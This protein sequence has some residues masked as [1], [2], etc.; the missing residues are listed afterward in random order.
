MYTKRKKHLLAAII[1]PAATVGILAIGPLYF[2]SASAQGCTALPPLP[3]ITHLAATA[4]A[5]RVYAGGGG[6]PTPPHGS[7]RRISTIGAGKDVTLATSSGRVIE[8]YYTRAE[9][10]F[11][12]AVRPGLYVVTAY[13]NAGETIPLCKPKT[14][15]VRKHERKIVKLSCSSVP[16]V[17]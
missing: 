2:R 7:C 6:P 10:V 4:I 16:E 1:M 14:V 13:L 9:G 3:P 8:I 11:R 17:V 15:R 12:F 5:G